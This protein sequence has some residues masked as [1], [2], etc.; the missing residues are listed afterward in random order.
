MKVEKRGPATGVTHGFH[1]LTEAGAG[2]GDE[3]IASVPQIVEVDS[4]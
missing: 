2:L 1:Q 4:L 3:V